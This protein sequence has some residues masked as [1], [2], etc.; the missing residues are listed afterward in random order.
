MLAA[1]AGG[2]PD[3]G[4]AAGGGSAER[5][6]ESIEDLQLRLLLEDVLERNPRLARLTAE[7]AAVEQRAPQVKALPDPTATLT[8]FVMSPETRVGPQRA[9]VNLM[10][11]LPWFGTL[12]VDERASL[13]DAVAARAIFK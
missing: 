1:F 5:I 9:T 12:K 11:Q 13:W 2:A 3:V 8:W 7:F 6:V 10:Q 4:A